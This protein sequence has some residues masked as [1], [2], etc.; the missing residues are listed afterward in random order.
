MVV[1][2]FY[3]LVFRVFRDGILVEETRSVEELWQ[4]SF[5]TFVIGCSFSF[6]AALQQAGLAVRHVEL[7][8]NV[9]MYNTN[10]AC[11]PAGSL[12][13]NL[14]VSM[15]PFSSADAVRAVQ[16]TSRY[17]RVHGAPVHIGDPV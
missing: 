13:G 14:V 16:V 17:P 8:R 3:T 4:D 7:G 11:T 1:A 10:V 6:E 5:Y 9:P 12:S 15:R 2:Q